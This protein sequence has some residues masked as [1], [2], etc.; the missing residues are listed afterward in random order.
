[1]SQSGVVSGGDPNAERGPDGF[2]PPP[3]DP[4]PGPL[5]RAVAVID[6]IAAHGS[7]TAKELSEHTGLPLP[8][9]YRIANELCGV[10]YLVHLRSEKRFALGYALHD[11]AVRLHDDLG[12]VPQVRREIA[13]LQQT[14]GMATY[15]AIHRGMDF[16]IVHVVDSPAC[17][18]LR[19]MTFGFREN[20]H[21][22]AFGKLGL[23]DLDPAARRELLGDGPFPALTP[24]TLTDP[25]ELAAELDSIGADGVAWETEEFTVGTRCAAVPLRTELGTLIGSVALSAPVAA[26]AGRTTH[27][28]HLLRATAARVSRFY[29]LGTP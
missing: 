1:M 15:L 25:D 16:V 9:V 19:P 8:T 13:A 29:R 5:K 12:V 2:G 10:D 4:K 26:Y 3:R 22:T 28:E 17:R 6:A 14:T 7:S 23:S 24:H 18:R 20:P 21:A 27:V 11:L